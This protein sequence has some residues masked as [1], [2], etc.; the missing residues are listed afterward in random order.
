MERLC[1]EFICGF[2]A[3]DFIADTDS[4]PTVMG[5]ITSSIIPLVDIRDLLG[6]CVNGDYAFAGLSIEVWYRITY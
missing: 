4:L 1:L 2:V 5:Q 6:N 3:G